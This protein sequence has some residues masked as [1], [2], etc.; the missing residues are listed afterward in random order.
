MAKVLSGLVF[1]SCALFITYANGQSQSTAPAVSG[2]KWQDM[3]NEDKALFILDYLVNEKPHLFEAMI[4]AG[5]AALPLFQQGSGSEKNSKLINGLEMWFLQQLPSVFRHPAFNASLLIIGDEVLQG[6]NRSDIPPKYANNTEIVVQAALANTKF[7]RIVQRILSIGSSQ[8]LL[9]L[10]INDTISQQCYIDT[11][12]YLDSLVI[13]S[14]WA[15]KMV[16]ASGKPGGGVMKGNLHF[17]GN[18][19]QCAEIMAIIDRGSVIG[20]RYQA[21][22]RRFGTNYCRATFSIPKS[23]I[24]SMN[25]DT[26]GIALKVLW[27]LCLPVSCSSEDVVRLFKIGRVGGLKLPIEKAHCHEEPDL[28]DDPS[29]VAAIAV[30]ACF[31]ALIVIGTVYDTL[32]LIPN[33]AYQ[34]ETI[35]KYKLT[36][37]NTTGQSDEKKDDDVKEKATLSNGA[38]DHSAQT[39][40]KEEREENTM[41]K[42]L[43][44][45]SVYTNAPKILSAKKAR[46][47]IHCLHGI[48]F[49]SILWIILGHTYNYGLISNEGV[50]TT[51]NMVDAD[52]MIKRFTWQAVEGAGFAVDTFL[53]LSGMLNTWLFMNDQKRWRRYKCV[54]S[55]WIKYYM[56]RIW[57]LTPLYMVVLMTYGCLYRYM[58]D[59]PLWPKSIHAAEMCK[60][61]WWTN[62]LYINNLV[63]T[64][65]QCMGWS[66]YLANDMQFYVISPIFFVA[67]AI[68]P[69]LGGVLTFLLM[70]GGITAAGQQESVYNGNFFTMQQE[71][72]GYWKYVYIVPWTRVGAY[73]V[74]MLLGMLI[75][76]RAQKAFSRVVALI[77]WILAIGTGIF[78]VYITYTENKAGGAPWS[79]EVRAVYESMSRPLWATCVAWVIFACHNHRGGVINS[80]LSWNGI[81]PLS[82][83][84]YA[85]YLVHPVI[86]SVHVLSKRSLVYVNN[87]DIIYLFLGHTVMTYMAAF[88]YSVA[89]E[90]P[91]M[92]LDKLFIG[93]RHK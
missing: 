67:M 12:D 11:T 31:G 83:L 33:S 54:A 61:S 89:F 87:F 2:K 23:F 80:L 86:M 39:S 69:V 72:D 10:T 56:H 5:E 49:M 36:I 19:D 8:M 14:P 17:L 15:L 93:K 16:D 73:A 66:W 91:F 57:R 46:N 40:F 79:M 22:E 81:I 44:A 59:G 13:A 43:E 90:A 27:D 45:F 7:T 30:L 29:A 68:H 88:I 28:S 63:K 64:D 38:T 26:R 9:G 58:G 4:K 18:Y 71:N 42:I 1:V 65:K 34:P 6:L 32:K 62:L 3:S 20:R 41:G 51:A 35:A 78:L 25:V 55:Y 84:T 48:R 70:A 52:T 47:A 82:R 60:E 77:G 76:K 53:L 74:G 37:I 50:M 24:E 92:A 85:A 21:Q 75:A